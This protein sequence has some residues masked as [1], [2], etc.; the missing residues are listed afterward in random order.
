MVIGGAVSVAVDAFVT[1]QIQHK[2]Y[3]WQRAGIAFTAGAVGGLVGAAAIVPMATAAGASIGAA[4]GALTIVPASAVQTI[5]TVATLVT[6]SAA[7]AYSNVVI[8]EY[9]RIA[10]GALIDGENISPDWV[11]SDLNNHAPIDAAWGTTS[12]IVGSGVSN[13]INSNFLPPSN[14]SQT[15]ITGVVHGTGI[16]ASNTDLHDFIYQRKMKMMDQ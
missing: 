5:T 6:G 2:D 16:A 14:S 15:F 4:V 13:A 12:Y 10:V 7:S 8:S 9:R 11:A 3:S 1:T